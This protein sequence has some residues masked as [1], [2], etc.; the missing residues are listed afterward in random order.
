MSA[1]EL[2]IVP[3]VAVMVVLPDARLCANP[4]LLMVAVEVVPEDH[5]TELVRFCVLPSL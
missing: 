4:A 1:V 5:A 3:N 2:L